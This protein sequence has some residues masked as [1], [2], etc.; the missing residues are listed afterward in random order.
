MRGIDRHGNPAQGHFM[1]EF[2][3]ADGPSGTDRMLFNPSF[4][5]D[6]MYLVSGAPDSTVHVWNMATPG[7][8]E[9]AAW[10]GFAGVPTCVQWAPRRQ[11]VAV[12]DT[13]GVLS[14]MTLKR[15]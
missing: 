8:P 15:R 10:R 2:P 3:L 7:M 13:A 11:L 9:V 1:H 5:P 14:L 6:D 12:A 4:S